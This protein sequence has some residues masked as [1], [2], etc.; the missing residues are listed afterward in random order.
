MHFEL[1]TDH[2]GSAIR[3]NFGDF[4]PIQLR[5]EIGDGL[6]FNIRFQ[7]EVTSNGLVEVEN[8]TRLIDDEDA[9]FNRVEKPLE[10]TPLTGQPLND[11]LQS[12]SIKPAN[13]AQNFIEKTGIGS[14]W[15]VDS[16]EVDS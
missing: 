10:K 8:T 2:A 11:G 14:H 1:V 5:N 12:F 6:S 3:I 13:A 9:V 16:W 15:L 7:S 4:F